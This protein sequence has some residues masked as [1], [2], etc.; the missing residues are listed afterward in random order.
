MQTLASSLKT[1]V[2]TAVSALS[3]FL[4][5]S[6][7]IDTCFSK[8]SCYLILHTSPNSQQMVIMLILCSYCNVL[9]E[10]G[11]REWGSDKNVLNSCQNI[12]LTNGTVE[13]TYRT[14]HWLIQ[15]LIAK[16]IGFFGD[17]EGSFTVEFHLCGV[18]FILYL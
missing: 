9:Q 3:E 10:K 16:H 5:F 12:I 6:L 13:F 17:I 14:C 15:P 7:N 8:L 4:L 1:R 11:W 18:L 2:S